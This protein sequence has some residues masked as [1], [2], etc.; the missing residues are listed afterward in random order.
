MKNLLLLLLLLPILAAGQINTIVAKYPI[1]APSKENLLDGILGK[2]KF[3][4]DT[5]KNNFYE[6]IRRAPYNL[7]KYHLKFWN[8]GGTNPTYEANMHFSKI[9]NT[10]FINVPYFEENFTHKGF[11]FLKILDVNADFS[12]ITAVVV[13]DTILWNLLEPEVRQRIIKTLNN[14]AYYQDTVHFYKIK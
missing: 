13:H 9:G 10:Q 1:D 7:D 4:E 11:F 5:D 6:I 3:K 12:K 2:W 14:P 8:R